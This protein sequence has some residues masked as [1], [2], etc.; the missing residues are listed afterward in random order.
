MSITSESDQQQKTDFSALLESYPELKVW[1][2][3]VLQQSDELQAEEVWPVFLVACAERGVSAE[4]YPFIG[5]DRGLA[6]LRASMQEFRQ[7]HNRLDACIEGAAV[8]VPKTTDVTGVS[9]QSASIVAAPLVGVELAQKVA[10]GKRRHKKKK[11]KSAN[12]AQGRQSSEQKQA[13]AATTVVAESVETNKVELVAEEKAAEESHIVAEAVVEKGVEEGQA[14]ASEVAAEPVAEKVVGG[15]AL[16]ESD[17]LEAKEVVERSGPTER[18]KQ[19]VWRKRSPRPVRPHR[20]WTRRRHLITWTLVVVLLAAIVIPAGLLINFGLSAY[21]T[22]Q[23]LNTEAHSAVSHLTN[24]QKMFSGSQAHISDALNVTKLQ[25][26]Q[27]EFVASNQEFQRLQAQLKHSPTLATVV[28]YFPSYGTLLRSAQVASVIGID[29]AQLGQIVTSSGIRLLPSLKGP[30]L[31][32]STTPLVTQAMLN[33]VGSTIDQVLPLLKDIQVR[34]QN[35]SLSTLPISAQEKAKVGPLLQQLPGVIKDLGMARPL[36]GVAGWV[37]GVEQTR[38]FLVQTMDRAE[39][40]GTGGF[41]GQYGELQISGGRLAPFSLKDIS[42][43]EYTA[44]SANQGHLAP[45]QYRAW[46]PFANWGLRDS[47][48]SA[49]FPTT[50]QLAIDLYQQEVGQQVDGAISFTPVLIEHLLAI[51]GPIYMPGYNVTV[52]PQNLE[53]LLH[54][55]QLDNAGI[56]QQRI[57]QPGDSSTSTRKRF[58]N[59]VATL[60]LQKVRSASPTELLAVAHQVFADLKDR[61]LQV[62]F[63]NPAAE[64]ALASYSLDGRLDRSTTHDGLYIVQENLNASKASQ[65]VQTLMQDTVTLD[66]Q[67]GATHLLQLRLVYNQAGPVYGY[68]TYNDY[69]RVYVPSNSR[70]IA[71]DG[72]ATG[73]PLCGGDYGD[74]PVDGVYPNG[75]LICPAGQYQPGAFAPSLSGANGASWEPLQT[76]GGPTNTTSDE[77]GRAMFGGW[78]IVP[79]NCTMNVTLS[80]YVPPVSG[81]PYTLLVQRQAG[82]FPE[83]DLTILPDVANCV[84]TRTSGLHFAKVLASDVSFTLPVQKTAVQGCYPHTGV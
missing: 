7:E 44:T 67:G 57:Y 14:E 41:T 49:D 74:C 45:P 35:L 61:E 83:L 36:L 32:A 29:V 77:A 59:Y 20:R 79:K 69:L 48:I 47:N 10:G 39:L 78:V 68:D 37:L 12:A 71:G 42:L 53:D 15:D 55:Y 11:G 16:E 76:I 73:T 9:S 18:A 46:W 66:A 75:E 70:L 64:A 81:Q 22:Y 17:G 25:E 23:N 8:D 3:E 51:V 62:Y 31:A 13:T 33:T 4:G 43:V 30:I 2:A 65:Y 21:A 60:F 38:T 28:N 6:A 40:R 72:F 52:T 5:G 84:E 56:G 34:T 82:T 80:W 58:T 26:A 54:Y 27:K 24:V 19:S 1:L 63:T 50:A